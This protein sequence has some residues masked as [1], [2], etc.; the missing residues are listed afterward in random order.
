[1]RLARKWEADED[2]ELLEELAALEVE[3]LHGVTPEAPDP[4][5]A[6]RRYRWIA[7]WGL[8]LEASAERRPAQGRNGRRRAG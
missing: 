8:D 3:E 4:R 6:S 1:M 5:F 7:L 2:W